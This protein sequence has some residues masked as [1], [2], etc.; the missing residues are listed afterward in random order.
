MIPFEKTELI[1]IPISGIGFWFLAPQLPGQLTIG[2]LLLT[3]SV[4]LL[5]QS[6]IRDL[7]LLARTKRA[8][9]SDHKKAMRCMCLES[10]VG[11]TGIL[12]S[13]G[14]LGFGAL[15]II[16]LNKWIWSGLVVLILGTGFVIKDLIID[17]RPWRIVRDKEHMN[18]VFTWKK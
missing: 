2:H 12:I 17:S 5:L 14:M 11:M 15:P 8:S 6:L 18:I 16:L 13:I 1:L 7:F 9:S 3:M 10:T 4:L